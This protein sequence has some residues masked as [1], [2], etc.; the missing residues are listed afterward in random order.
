MG[1]SHAVALAKQGAD[2][3]LFDLCHGL[4]TV[5]YPPST[6]E[7]LAETAN[8]VEKEGRR[9]LAMQGD[10]RAF[11]EVKDAVERVITDLGRID[12]VVANAGIAGGAPIQVAN[13]QEWDDI[14]A[15]NLTGV[16]HTL[17]AAAPVMIKQKYG[18]MVAISSMMGRGVTGGIAAYAASKWGVIG[19]VKSAAQDLA[20]FGITVNALAPGTI[21]TPMVRNDVLVKKVR[22]DLAEPTFEDAAKF[23]GLLHVQPVPVLPPQ[24]VSDALL[25]LVGPGSQH[26]TGAVIDV[27]AG[28]SARVTA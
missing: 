2:V 27:S 13:A 1:R 22:P 8:L 7:D 18:R 28:A 14:I 17:R 9:C 11:Q 3:A 16:F 23:L 15:T 6:P 20:G 5:D 26:I 4:E 25:F 12:I 24:A 21:D 10:V 19:L